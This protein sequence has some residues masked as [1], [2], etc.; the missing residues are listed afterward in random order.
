MVW[1]SSAEGRLYVAH[2][3]GII[4]AWGCEPPAPHV[5][6][7]N[8]PSELV[9]PRW[10]VAHRGS[11]LFRLSC[12]FCSQRRRSPYLLGHF[13]RILFVPLGLPRV[14]PPGSLCSDPPPLS[15]GSSVVVHHLHPRVSADREHFSTLHGAGVDEDDF[16]CRGFPEAI[17]LVDEPFVDEHLHGLRL[18][19]K[20]LLKVGFVL[21]IIGF[22]LFS[23][24]PVQSSGRNLRFG[25]GALLS[26]D[27]NSEQCSRTCA[28]SFF[29]S[30]ISE[31][32]SSANFFRTS[33]NSLGPLCVH[34]LDHL[35]SWALRVGLVHQHGLLSLDK[36]SG[37]LLL[38]V[39]L[40]LLF[41]TGGDTHEEG[42]S[43]RRWQDQVRRIDQSPIRLPDFRRLLR[44]AWEASSS[45]SHAPSRSSSAV[46]F[47]HRISV[48]DCWSNTH[49]E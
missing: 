18:I 24:H 46:S 45:C 41:I 12:K 14:S 11:L 47:K 48:R 49:P 27:Q 25:L 10:L 7:L 17:A 5:R 31:A 26:A 33:R 15:L 13:V 28:R 36:T 9:K 21:G 40:V 29:T 8:V 37:H 44:L 1:P 2:G 3:S 22:V 43:F 32:T 34:H 35:A 20:G 38:L 6:R 42:L 16:A 23:L 39:G 19:R 30:V 4:A